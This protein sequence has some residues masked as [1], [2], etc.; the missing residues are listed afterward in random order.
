MYRYKVK[1]NA[2]YRRTRIPDEDDDWGVQ[3]PTRRKPINSATQP[4]TSAT[5]RTTTLSNSD[6]KTRMATSKALQSRSP[7]ATVAPLSPSKRPRSDENRKSPEN[8]FL[9]NRSSFGP[10]FSTIENYS[11]APLDGLQTAKYR[12]LAYPGEIEPSMG[13]SATHSRPQASIR[14]IAA[15][16][17]L[18]EDEPSEHEIMGRNNHRHSPLFESLQ[19][20][21]PLV[22]RRGRTLHL[23]DPNRE[24]D[25]DYHEK[26]RLQAIVDTVKSMEASHYA[27]NS[28]EDARDFFPRQEEGQ[29]EVREQADTRGRRRHHLT[30]SRHHVGEDVDEQLRLDN[31]IG[32]ATVKADLRM[33][34]MVSDLSSHTG[35]RTMMDGNMHQFQ[36][37]PVERAAFKMQKAL[38]QAKTQIYPEYSPTFSSDGEED[39]M[40]SVPPEGDETEDYD[41]FSHRRQ[42]KAGLRTANEFPA[43]TPSS[44]N[45]FMD[46]PSADMYTS[47][48]VKPGGYSQPKSPSTTHTL[49]LNAQASATPRKSPLTNAAGHTSDPVQKRHANMMPHTLHAAGMEST[50]K[51]VPLQRSQSSDSMGRGR[52]LRRARSATPTKEDALHPDVQSSG[53]SLFQRSR[54]SSESRPTTPNRLVKSGSNMNDSIR[55]MD[56]VAEQQLKEI[57][58][59]RNYRVSN[60]GP[61]DGLVHVTDAPQKERK[62]AAGRR[63][64]EGAIVNK[65]RWLTNGKKSR[66][67]PHELPVEM[68]RHE[69]AEEFMSH[70]RLGDDTQR[71]PTHR[72]V[73]GREMANRSSFRNGSR[74]PSPRE[75]EHHRQRIRDESRR[76]SH[77]RTEDEPRDD[78]A[79]SQY[80]QQRHF[81][82]TRSSNR[83]EQDYRQPW[84]STSQE[85]YYDEDPENINHFQRN[86][87]L[88]RG[89]EQSKFRR[90]ISR[91]P[92]PRTERQQRHDNVRDIRENGLR[93]DG[94]RSTSRGKDRRDSG[95]YTDRDEVRSSSRGKGLAGRLSSILGSFDTAGRPGLQPHHEQQRHPPPSKLSDK[96]KYDMMDFDTLMNAIGNDRKN[97]LGAEFAVVELGDEETAIQTHAILMN[98]Q[99]IEHQLLRQAR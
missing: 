76:A 72:V 33:E 89:M 70:G 88:E 64:S 94:M 49:K 40:V 13:R 18:E 96:L 21:T 84:E 68:T 60:I 41:R 30:V 34:A 5:T 1:N 63:K 58:A 85:L 39:H 92:S 79:R 71:H 37:G 10:T 75:P 32:L 99:D 26:K 23:F 25:Y 4:H 53:S 90:S 15:R 8:E 46:R 98:R 65:R 31:E 11:P 36:K 66:Q 22:G 12:N 50:I 73:L 67:V 83:G 77:P 54:L 17:R 69:S 56:L 59:R 29:H 38:S 19:E 61:G 86:R 97:T 42:A 9:G 44:S 48:P 57:R 2:L 52:F 51:V 78:F 14:Q 27:E 93:T 20:K 24:E 47:S 43:E 7:K 16:M 35:E 87:S 82:R 95:G 6:N 55:F 74:S 81:S 3:T 62:N 91:S 80:T 28:R 45:M